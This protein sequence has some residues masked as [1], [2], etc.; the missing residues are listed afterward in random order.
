[1]LIWGGLS[2]SGDPLMGQERV[3]M[4]WVRQADLQALGNLG[5][6]AALVFGRMLNDF[7][8]PNL[9]WAMFRAEQASS[10]SPSAPRQGVGATK[11]ICQPGESGVSAN[12]I[13]A[14]SCQE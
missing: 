2:L 8:L 14:S 3:I 6:Q 1:M 13:L 9:G 7:F 10:A 4:L 11:G 12:G 5:N